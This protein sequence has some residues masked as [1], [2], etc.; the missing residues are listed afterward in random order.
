MWEE[1]GPMPMRM[2]SKTLRG[3]GACSASIA[4]ARRAAGVAES[5]ALETRA[6]SG[7]TADSVVVSTPVSLVADVVAEPTA[8][9]GA[10]VEAERLW[11]V[12]P[13]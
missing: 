4:P 3:R 2:R 12:T 8:K 1:E 7:A 5:S 11:R 13:P 6:V 9:S 10:F